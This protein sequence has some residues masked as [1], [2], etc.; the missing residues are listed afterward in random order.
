MY[1]IR[2][3][4]DFWRFFYHKCL[5]KRRQSTSLVWLV[6]LKYKVESDAN[7]NLDAVIAFIQWVL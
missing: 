5:V 7:Y 4:L 6:Y 1:K 3:A 2:N